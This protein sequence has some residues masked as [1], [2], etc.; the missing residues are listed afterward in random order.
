VLGY[1]AGATVANVEFLAATLVPRGYGIPGL[2]AL[3]GAGGKVVNAAG[4]QF[5]HRYHPRGDLAARPYLVKG[6]LSEIDA[7][8]GPC[9]IDCSHL[10][11]ST[12]DELLH[13]LMLERGMW[14]EYFDQADVD[15]RTRPMEM[16]LSELSCVYGVQIDAES[17]S[18]LPGLYAA[19]ECAGASGL[20]RCCTE[21][22]RAG[23]SG[24]RF[25]LAE[26][27]RPDPDPAHVQAA[28]AL[29][30]HLSLP[31]AGLHYTQVENAIRSTMAQNVNVEKAEGGLLKARQDLL[32]VRRDS[33]RLRA[34]HPHEVLRSL[35][36]RSLLA[37]SLL[38]VEASLA[39]QESRIGTGAG[40]GEMFWRSDYPTLN[41]PEWEKLVTLERGEGGPVVRVRPVPD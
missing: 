3:M 14:D 33:T 13:H 25:A 4:E 40:S 20:A 9:S 30:D 19:G 28:V 34:A 15:L 2:A 29:L 16:E 32:D 39:R 27:R 7:G 35:E 8:R 22:F 10:S 26:G 18:A 37:F 41:A 24:A 6:V 38:T 12:Q 11:Q 21:G 31:E 1:E 17:A 23:S 36:A 5:M